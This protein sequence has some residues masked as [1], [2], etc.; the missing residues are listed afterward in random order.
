MA[1]PVD[2]ILGPTQVNI[3]GLEGGLAPNVIAPEASA[4]LLFRIVTPYE[5]VLAA[6]EPIGHLV[7]VEYAYHVP[8]LHMT[9]LEGFESDRGLLLLDFKDLRS[10]LQFLA[11]D[12]ARGELNEYGTMSRQTVNGG[13]DALSIINGAAILAA[14]LLRTIAVNRRR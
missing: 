4:D 10:V 2:E 11:S 1:L 12:E 14:T 13:T 8:A 5:D 6:L 9:A 7:D 3:G